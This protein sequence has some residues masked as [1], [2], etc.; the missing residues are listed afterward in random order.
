MNKTGFNNITDKE[1]KPRI[2]G[3]T[4][5]ALNKTLEEEPQQ[6]QPQQPQY[7]F[8]NRQKYSSNDI[9][10]TAMKYPQVAKE[11]STHNDQVDQMNRFD[12]EQASK[13]AKEER[14]RI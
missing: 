9:M 11:M 4:E 10:R 8:A 7:N 6:Q 5:D 13:K 3:F 14:G 1:E 2:K 12:A